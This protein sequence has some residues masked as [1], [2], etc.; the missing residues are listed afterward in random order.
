MDTTLPM[1]FWTSTVRVSMGVGEENGVYVCVGVGDVAARA[2]TWARR[3]FP[4]V[5]KLT[6]ALAMVRLTAGTTERRLREETVPSTG[7]REHRT[8][9]CGQR[10]KSTNERGDPT[11]LVTPPRGRPERISLL[12]D[13]MWSKFKPFE[14]SILRLQDL[15]ILKISSIAQVET[16]E[17][18]ALELGKVVNVVT[19]SKPFCDETML[20]ASKFLAPAR[21]RPERTSRLRG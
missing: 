7:E 13:A 9:K 1:R 4:W 14:Q 12:S 15:D 18:I 21:S 16:R 8:L 6:S 10:F 20:V 11:A 17:D 5:K 3:G 19:L 2:L